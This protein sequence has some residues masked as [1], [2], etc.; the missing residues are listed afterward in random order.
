MESAHHFSSRPDCNNTA[1]VPSFTLGTALLQS[2]LFL[3]CVVLTYNDSRKDLHKLC[4]IPGNCQCNWLLVSTLARRT[5]ASF[6]VFPGKF[7]FCTGM[8]ASIGWPSPA[9]RLHIDDCFE[10]HNFQDCNHWVAKSC[11]TTAYRRLFRDSLSSVIC[12]NQI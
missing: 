1:D 6:S 7:L 8:T 10:I 11:T 4:Q 12:S 3:I 2:H 5:F 9:P